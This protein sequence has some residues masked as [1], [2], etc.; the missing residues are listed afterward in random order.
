MVGSLSSSSSLR[1]ISPLGSP[2]AEGASQ[3][4]VV[5]PQDQ[6]ELGIENSSRPSWLPMLALA[7]GGV[8]ALAGCGQA[9][10]QNQVQVQQQP[11]TP[12]QPL[13]QEALKTREDVLLR[14]HQIEGSQSDALSNFRLIEGSLRRDE[15]LGEAAQ[16]FINLL[17]AVGPG[18]TNDAQ[19][20]YRTVSSRLA[21][22]ES[23]SQAVEDMLR[24]YRAEGNSSDAMSNYRLIHSRVETGANRSQ[25][26]DQFLR[27]LEQV[28]NG[29]TSD[30]QT[31]FRVLNPN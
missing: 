3:L 26:T 25:S 4:P 23:R 28:G 17:Q 13:S 18:R 5:E 16:S 19:A 11:T 21:Q 7:A 2:K 24:L 20:A 29:R 8:V 27:L 10:P 15:D 30:A 6:V 31:M 1:Q 9:P 14:L 12:S 22:E